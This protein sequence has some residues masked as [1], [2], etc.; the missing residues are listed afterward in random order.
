M[1]KNNSSRER[2]IT[3]VARRGNATRSHELL[4]GLPGAG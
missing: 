2:S 3:N 1:L 4:H